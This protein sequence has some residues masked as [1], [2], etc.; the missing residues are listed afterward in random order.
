MSEL[1]ELMNSP[2]TIDIESTIA[3]ATKIMLEKK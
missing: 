3:D 2:I 1:E